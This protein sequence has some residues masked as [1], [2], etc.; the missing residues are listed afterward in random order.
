MKRLVPARKKPLTEDEI[1]RRLTRLMQ[2]TED[3]EEYP[4]TFTCR[5]CQDIGYLLRTDTKAI[6]WSR[7]CVECDKGQA[8]IRGELERQAKREKEIARKAKVIEGR[9]EDL[10][11]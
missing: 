9:G 4:Q 5:Q 2:L 1:K 7:P 3:R 8:I 6:V 11:I 10:P